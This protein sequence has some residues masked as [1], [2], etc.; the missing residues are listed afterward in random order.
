VGHVLGVAETF[1]H[2]SLFGH[3]VTLERSWKR[4]ERHR[5]ILCISNLFEFDVRYLLMVLDGGVVSRDVAGQL[6][7]VGSHG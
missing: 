7:E 5:D 4:V 3:E 1:V 2:L 6:G